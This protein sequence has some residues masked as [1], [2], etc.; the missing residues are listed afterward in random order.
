MPAPGDKVAT[1]EQPTAGQI[2][3][4]GCLPGERPVALAI[5][6]SAI[7]VGAAVQIQHA[8]SQLGAEVADESMPWGKA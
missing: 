2:T 1:V 3:S 8:G 4:V 7:P 5:V 6:A